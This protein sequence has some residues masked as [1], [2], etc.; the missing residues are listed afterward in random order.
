M[1]CSDDIL[2]VVLDALVREPHDPIATPLWR[3]TLVGN[4]EDVGIEEVGDFAGVR[5]IIEVEG[6]GK[7]SIL[8]EE[9]NEHTS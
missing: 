4:R 7:Y 1:L 6:M 9:C 2:D 3:T 8:V 5:Q